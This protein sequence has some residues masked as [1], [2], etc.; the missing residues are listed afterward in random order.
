MEGWRVSECVCVCV[1]SGGWLRHSD[2]QQKG[3]GSFKACLHR[4]EERVLIGLAAHGP[5]GVGCRSGKGG[6]L[7]PLIMGLF[8]CTLDPRRTTGV[9]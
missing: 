3:R 8:P 7:H 2:R 1:Q 4:G 6:A 5:H 9:S